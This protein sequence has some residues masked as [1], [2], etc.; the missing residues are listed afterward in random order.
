MKRWLVAATV[1]VLLGL[2][3]DQVHADDPPGRPAPP[4]VLDAAAEAEMRLGRRFVATVQPTQVS[5][6]GSE[7][8]GYVEQVHVE[9]GDYVEKDAKLVSLRTR[10][11]EIRIIAATAELTL[12]THQLEELQNGARKE[13]LSQAEALLAESEAEAENAKWRLDAIRSLK[14]GTRSEEELREAER[15]YGAAKARHAA[16][17]AALALLRAGA[18]TEV[19]A[20]AQARVDAQKAELTRLEDEK[21][22]HTISAP[23]P[24]FIAKKHTDAGGWLQ[25]GD[26]AVELVALASVDIVVRVPEEDLVHLKQGAEVT[27]EIDALPRDQLRGTVFRI[28]PVAS[29]RSR[30]A[31]VKVRVKNTIVDG[32]PRIKAGMFARVTLPVGEQGKALLVHK[33]AVVLG[34]R[35][36]TVFRFDRGSGTVQPVPITLGVSQGDRIAVTGQIT[37]GDELVVRG[38]ERLRPGAKVRPVPAK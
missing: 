30:T 35:A 36:P 28:V 17:E 13:E 26:A 15:A 9:E 29:P 37:A 14:Q 2:P 19:I 12:R 11:L 38:N 7:A 20:Q 8:D 6:V 3:Q 4:V 24:G 18:R 31:P 23:F 16:R 22:R 10:T 34:G 1:L 32:Q 5:T 27:V 33:D 21:T 25:R